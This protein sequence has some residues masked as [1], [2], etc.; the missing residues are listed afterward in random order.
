V[1]GRRN[2]FPIVRRAIPG[3][4]A[5]FSRHKGLCFA[6]GDLTDGAHNAKDRSLEHE[7]SHADVHEDSHTGHDTD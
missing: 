6:C 5:V 3:W 7:T 1:P 4:E 2:T